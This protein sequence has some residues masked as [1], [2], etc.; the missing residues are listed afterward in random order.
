M[1][2]EEAIKQRHSVRKYIHKPLSTEVVRALEE[3]ILECNKEGGLHIQLV[4][5][6]TKAFSGIM[7]YGKFHGV[8]NY[9]ADAVSWSVL[10]K[11]DFSVACCIR[12]SAGNS[13]KRIRNLSSLNFSM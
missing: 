12:L 2:I 5:Q 4:T 1:T 10:S 9:L 11:P 8:E 7:S 13:R 3:K 6:E